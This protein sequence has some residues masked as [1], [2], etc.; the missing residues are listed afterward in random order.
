MEAFLKWV[1]GTNVILLIQVGCTITAQQR[2]IRRVDYASLQTALT[3]VLRMNL[4]NV[5][6]PVRLAWAFTIQHRFMQY[7]GI[8][9]SHYQRFSQTRPESSYHSAWCLLVCKN[10]W[11]ELRI[12]SETEFSQNGWERHPRHL[13]QKCPGTGILL[14]CTTRSCGKNQNS[15]ASL[16]NWAFSARL[17]NFLD[18]GFHDAT[19]RNDIHT[20]E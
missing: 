15:V 3:A 4:T 2:S 20:M 17:H 19:Y 1:R 5:R 12:T 16:L 14:S 11:R 9:T 6:S 7:F 8:W 10:W 18:D 13:F